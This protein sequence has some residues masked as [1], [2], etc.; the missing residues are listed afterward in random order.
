VPVLSIFGFARRYPR[1]SMDVDDR[2]EREREFHDARFADDSDGRPADR[3][4]AVNQASDR[5]YRAEIDRAPAGAKVLDYGCGEGAFCALHA[6]RKGYDVVA[7]D[8]SPVAIDHARELAERE[9]VAERIDFRV[10]NAEEMDLPE[11]SFD[12]VSG[13]GVLHHLD[14]DGSMRAI[15]RVMKPDGFGVFVEP[16]GH[17]PVINMYRRRTPEQRS[18]D[19]HPLLVSDFDTMRRHFGELDASYFHLLG[20][21]AMPLH[22]RPSFGRALKAL[23]AADRALFR[24]VKPL[25]RH[26]W[27]VGLRVAKPLSG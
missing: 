26:A 27:M 23:D 16:M 14:I 15:A 13:L 2:L 20:L 21:M 11:A 24:A 1:Q 12:V 8:I 3:F 5:W 22:G 10:M 4:Y 7:I 6:A 18:V 9:G 19:E 17:N 25:R